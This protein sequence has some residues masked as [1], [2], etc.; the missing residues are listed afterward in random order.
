MLLIHI[1]QEHRLV[2]EANK[3]LLAHL[4]SCFVCLFV[5]VHMLKQYITSGFFF[6][7]MWG[8]VV[9]VQAKCRWTKFQSKL[10]GRTKCQLILGLGGQNPSLIKSLNILNAGVIK[11][12]S[13]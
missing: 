3:V 2:R 9:S 5:S 13:K 7:T 6:Q 12:Q 10:Q 11:S 1:T 8:I 4:S